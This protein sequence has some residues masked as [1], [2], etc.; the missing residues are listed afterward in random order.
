MVAEHI[1]SDGKENNRCN[2]RRKEAA[3]NR[4]HYIQ[5]CHNEQQ[6]R[7]DLVPARE[8]AIKPKARTTVNNDQGRS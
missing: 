3:T 2:V 8:Q 5:I 6:Y 7:I 1:K 4:D